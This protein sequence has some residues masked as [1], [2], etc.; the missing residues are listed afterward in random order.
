[1]KHCPYCGEEIQDTAI[2][3]RF[4]G[5]DLVDDVEKIAHER[6]LNHAKANYHYDSEKIND[7]ND[8]NKNLYKYKP[9]EIIGGFFLGLIF[10]ISA[11][12]FF[13][14]IILLI[15]DYLNIIEKDSDLIIFIVIIPLYFLVVYMAAK[16]RYKKP[17]LISYIVTMFLLW[18]PMWGT[19][20]AGLFLLNSILG[21]ERLNIVSISA[22]VLLIIDVVALIYLLSSIYY[23]N[24]FITSNNNPLVNSKDTSAQYSKP[25]DSTLEVIKQS[26][27]TPIPTKTRIPTPTPECLKFDPEK[28]WREGASICIYSYNLPII[29]DYIF[30]EEHNQYIVDDYPEFSRDVTQVWFPN[31]IVEVTFNTWMYYDKFPP[32]TYNLVGYTLNYNSR[33]LQELKKFECIRILGEIETFDESGITFPIIHISVIEACSTNP[34]P[35]RLSPSSPGYQ[36]LQMEREEQMW[37]DMRDR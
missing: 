18:I 33:K 20:Y 28:E 23:Q 13:Y 34:I 22:F 36:I 21:R 31:P 29:E 25:I 8:K 6:K 12:F 10:I 24:S 19:F 35:E 5:K 1:M 11:L 32:T 7:D 26:T 3:C 30:R 27:P 14:S 16:G 9:L 17:D 37:K 2:V 4:C 15:A